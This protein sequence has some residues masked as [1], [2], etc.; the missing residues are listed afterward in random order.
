[1]KNINKYWKIIDEPSC[2]EWQHCYP[3]DGWQTYDK[4]GGKI[5]NDKKNVLYIQPLLFNQNS[6][7]S[8]NLLK[9]LEKWLSAF[10]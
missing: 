2:D 7:I 9:G 6:S 10:Y 3:K 1:L 8:Q 4:F 5:I